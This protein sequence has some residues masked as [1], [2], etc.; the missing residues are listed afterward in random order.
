MAYSIALPPDDPRKAQRVYSAIQRVIDSSRFCCDMSMKTARRSISIEFRNVRLS[1]SKPYCGNHAGPCLRG[2]RDRKGNW[3]EGRDWVSFNDMLN[4]VLDALRISANVAS[5]VCVVR[6][7]RKRC[8]RYIGGDGGEWIR[9]N[10][11]SN[12]ADCIGMGPQVAEVP[13]GT[14]GITGYTETSRLIEEL[15]ETV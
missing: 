9:N 7:G 5:S 3:L 10:D 11:P 13:D 2:G 6:I 12:F 8:V 4:D 15:A 1:T 14:P